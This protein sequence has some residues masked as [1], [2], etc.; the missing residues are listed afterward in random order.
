[1]SHATATA[2]PPHHGLPADADPRLLEIAAFLL[3]H[4]D[5]AAVDPRGLGPHLL[6]HLF[7]LV[8]ETDVGGAPRLKIRLTGTAVDETFDRHVAG[9]CMEDFMHGPRSVD[10]LQN[11]HLCAIRRQPVWMRQV[12]TFAERYSR[13]IE[14]VIVP[15]RP[16]RLYGGL[17]QGDAA[18][19]GGHS[20][21]E[22]VWLSFD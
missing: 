10:V 7:I 9:R 11:F 4:D 16:D 21:F 8:R 1:M 15:L 18:L 22:C 5:A 19:C 13:F 14:G 6:P 2:G 20:Q 17:V 3:Q 12:V